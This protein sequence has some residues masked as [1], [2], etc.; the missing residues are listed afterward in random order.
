M[1]A[2]E[3]RDKITWNK[4]SQNTRT[5]ILE[6][7][8]GWSYNVIIPNYMYNEN[9]TDYLIKLGYEVDLEEKYVRIKC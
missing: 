1:N 5:S 4:L 7:S 6:A 9:D 8:H 3:L 2:K